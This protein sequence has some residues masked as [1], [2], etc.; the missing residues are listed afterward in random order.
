LICCILLRLVSL[1]SC[2]WSFVPGRAGHGKTQL[3]S[4][5]AR[6]KS[7]KSGA[8]KKAASVVTEVQVIAEKTGKN[9]EIKEVKEKRTTQ[10]AN[11]ALISALKGPALTLT[12]ELK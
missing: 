7:K 12:S 5:C 9:N 10:L 2:Q 3:I 8:K 6:R 4:R 11:Q 1:A